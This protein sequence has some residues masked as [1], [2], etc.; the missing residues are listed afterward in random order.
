MNE[1]IIRGIDWLRNDYACSIIIAGI[2][3]PSV[4][5]AYQAQKFTDLNIKNEIANTPDVKTVRKIGRSYS[6]RDN[7]DDVRSTVMET[8]LRQKF[9][10]DQVL[11]ERLA[12]TGSNAI[13]MTEYDHFWGIGDDGYGENKLGNL[14]QIVRSELQILYGIDPNVNEDDFKSLKD[15]VIIYDDDDYAIEVLETCQILFDTSM[16]LDKEL[17]ENLFDEDCEDDEIALIKL[18]AWRD[19]LH[20]LK[21]LLTNRDNSKDD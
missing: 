21:D 10:N 1:I 19:A 16:I 4:E 12:R 14:L 9:Y 8:L 13:V 17:T 18:E 6:I 2:T 3:Y 7:W 15:V 5:H 11:G 20:N